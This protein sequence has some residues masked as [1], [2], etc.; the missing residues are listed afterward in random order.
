VLSFTYSTVSHEHAAI[1][2]AYIAHETQNT[3]LFNSLPTLLMSYITLFI[4]HIVLCSRVHTASCSFSALSFILAVILLYTLSF[5][6]VYTQ[7]PVP[8]LLSPSA[9]LSSYFP[10]NVT[11][12]SLLIKHIVLCSRD[13]HNALLNYC[14]LLTK[15]TVLCS[16]DT[17]SVL[18]I[19]CSLTH[20]P[21]L[22]PLNT[23]SFTHV[24]YT[25]RLLKYCT[26]LTKHIVLG[27]RDTHSVLLINMHI[28]AL[29]LF[30]SLPQLCC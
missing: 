13:T 1:F 24:I 22:L 5:A 6:H 25:T 12:D 18:L 4:K 9:L 29:L 3:F 15:H 21:L 10:F 30:R 16:R 23:L 28:P 7:R 14:T 8:S 2:P 19:H 11:L 26:L 20:C 27:S 17:L